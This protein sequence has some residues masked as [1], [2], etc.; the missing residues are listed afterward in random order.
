MSIDNKIEPIVINN[1]SCKRYF[2]VNEK[3][4]Y[5]NADFDSGNLQKVEQLAPYIVIKNLISSIN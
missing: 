5:F 2:L 4:I 1:K 3:K